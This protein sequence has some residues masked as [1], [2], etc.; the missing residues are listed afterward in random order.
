MAIS[1]VWLSFFN[2]RKG[3]EVPQLICTGV[4]LAE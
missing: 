1:V 4:V 3:I 2:R